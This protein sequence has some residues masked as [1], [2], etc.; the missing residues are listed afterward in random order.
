MEANM[1]IISRDIATDGL[2]LI[3]DR[4]I[5]EKVHPGYR[6]LIVDL[7]NKDNIDP[8]ITFADVSDDYVLYDA[9]KDLV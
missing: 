7:L 6:K 9:C 2:R 8:N 1:K 3:S 4:V 5:C